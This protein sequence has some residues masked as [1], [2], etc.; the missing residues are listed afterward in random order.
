MRRSSSRNPRCFA[1]YARRLRSCRCRREA[2]R[3]VRPHSVGDGLVLQ[4][5]GW[6]I[7]ASEAD[8]AVGR[9]WRRAP[10]RRRALHSA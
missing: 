8:E 7:A 3:G 9:E 2:E 5:G 4:G 10:V 6:A 1:R